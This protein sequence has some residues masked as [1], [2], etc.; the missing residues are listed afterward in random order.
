MKALRY[1]GRKGCKDEAYQSAL[2][3]ND[4]VVVSTLPRGGNVTL[5]FEIDG[6]PLEIALDK[7]RRDFLDLATCVYV[8]DEVVV[9][10]KTPTYWTRAFDVVFPVH[11]PP[12][13]EAARQTLE[14]M[15]WTLAGDEYKFSFPLTTALQSLGSH[16]RY[17]P[18][19]YDAVCLFSGGMD[20]LLGAYKLLTEGKRVLLVGHQADGTAARAQSELAAQLAVMFPPVNRLPRFRLIQCRAARSMAESQRFALPDKCE[21]THR[22][23]SLLF[24]ALAVAVAGAT[25]SKEIYIPENGLIALNPV[26]QKSRLGTLSTRTAHPLF[27]SKFSGLAHSVGVFDGTINNPFLYMSKTDML[28]PATVDSKLTPLLERSVSCARASRYKDKGVRHC[29]YCVPCLYRR[30]SMME[31]GLDNP[32][33]YAFDVFCGLAEMSA[34]TQ[35]DFRA[36]VS[37]AKTVVGSTTVQR[38]AMLLSHGAFSPSVGERFGPH[39]AEGYALWSDMLL[40]WATDFMKKVRQLSSGSTKKILAI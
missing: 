13:W 8:L 10:E 1:V 36:L 2:T 30:V 19:G 33:H 17:V 9:R 39:A 21:E 27:L 29:G 40:R 6:K 31:L 32:D 20:S 7:T 34:L 11:E 14:S 28:S 23:R 4:C 37:F 38:E 24:L 3:A 16:R 18:R 12:R 26:L 22:P 25:R 15:L 35:V 5:R